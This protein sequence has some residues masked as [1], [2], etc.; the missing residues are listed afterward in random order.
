[1]NILGLLAYTEYHQH[2]N[3]EMNLRKLLMIHYTELLDFWVIGANALAKT[4]MH[5]YNEEPLSGK[6]SLV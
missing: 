1:M 4:I 2:A 5:W 3:T 6:K